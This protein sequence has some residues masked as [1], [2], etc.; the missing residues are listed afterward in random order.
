[1]PLFNKRLQ[2]DIL[3]F[4]DRIMD[5]P[6]GVLDKVGVEHHEFASGNHGRKLDFNKITTDSDFYIDWVAIYAR[7]IVASYPNNLPDALIGIANGANRLSESIAH[8]LGKQ[9]LGLTTQKINTTS[10]RLNEEAI[11]AMKVY[12]VQF[13]LTIEDVGTTGGTTATAVQHLQDIGI[14]RIESFNGW[15]RN[16]SLPY[17]DQLDIPYNALIVHPLRMFT[18]EACHTDPTGYCHNNIPLIAHDKIEI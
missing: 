2:H 1:M 18:P 16:S 11:D 10:V 14:E 5:D 9:V 6:T 4:R 3:D 15:Q 12:N 13:A 8:L 7:A 17:L